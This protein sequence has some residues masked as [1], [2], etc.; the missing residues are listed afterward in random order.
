MDGSLPACPSVTNALS[1]LV[2]RRTPGGS[3]FHIR[4]PKKKLLAGVKDR[5]T[6]QHN[7]KA[8]LLKLKLKLSERPRVCCTTRFWNGLRT[9]FGQNVASMWIAKRSHSLLDGGAAAALRRLCGVKAFGTH[10]SIY[11]RHTT[12]TSCCLRPFPRMPP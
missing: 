4:V 2:R 10:A 11:V 7:M 3:V 8:L 6:Q 1:L 5:Q 12:G 9:N